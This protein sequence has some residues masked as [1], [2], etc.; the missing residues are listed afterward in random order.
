MK[1]RLNFSPQPFRDS[2]NLPLT[3]WVLN[4][5][6]LVALLGSAWY[7]LSLRG[8]NAQMHE[9]LSQLRGDQTVVAG[10]HAESVSELESIDLKDY[11][12][13]V[14]LYHSI[15]TGFD[16][17]WG[18]LLDDLGALVNDDVRIVSLRPMRGSSDREAQTATLISMSGEARNKEAQL[19]LV[20]TLQADSRF[21]HVRFE[22]EEYLDGDPALAFDI[23]FAYGTEG[24]Q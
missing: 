3:L 13:T 7:W 12:K 15:Q 5:V 4:L 16:T 6:L 10:D 20:R 17:R 22:T 8:D 23:S 2:S 11:R 21:D 24:G 18:A 1:S 19:A 14:Q 9:Q